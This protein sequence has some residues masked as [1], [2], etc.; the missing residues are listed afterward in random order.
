[1]SIS[2]QRRVVQ[3][4]E[5][6]GLWVRYTSSVLYLF[7]GQ[8]LQNVLELGTHSLRN[9]STLYHAQNNA[10]HSSLR[11]SLVPTEK[12]NQS[13]NRELKYKSNDKPVP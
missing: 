12:L 7:V 10:C 6:G 2:P 11:I 5:T 1:M 8:V 9:S 4:L 13:C 3:C